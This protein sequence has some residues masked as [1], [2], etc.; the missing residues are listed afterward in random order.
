MATKKVPY[1]IIRY[2]NGTVL[3][4]MGGV[5]KSDK[6]AKQYTSE[7]D[8]RATAAAINEGRSKTDEYW[9]SVE[10]AG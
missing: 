3:D 1:W 2:K 8:A 6:E 5:S 9:A 4:H 10:G 7:A